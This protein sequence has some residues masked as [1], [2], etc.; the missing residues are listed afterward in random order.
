[1][2]WTLSE[3]KF[4]NNCCVL[5]M[6]RVKRRVG[7]V[8]FLSRKVATRLSERVAVVEVA[9]LK[10]SKSCELEGKKQLEALG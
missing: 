2:P 4:N 7:T 5:R 6:V 9:R 1:M 3:G 8:L 10:Q